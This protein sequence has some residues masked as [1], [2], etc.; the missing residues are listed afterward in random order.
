MLHLVADLQTF[1]ISPLF[2]NSRC[3]ARI[4]LRANERSRVIFINNQSTTFLGQNKNKVFRG[5]KKSN[6]HVHFLAFSLFFSK[7]FKLEFILYVL[8]FFH[9]EFSSQ[10]IKRCCLSQY[11]TP[12][13]QFFP[14]IALLKGDSSS[15]VRVDPNFKDVVSNLSE[16]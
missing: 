1:K 8:S 6:T 14:K 5:Q 10:C 15:P 16:V 4:V 7:Y 9:S 2:R 3:I 13:N 11:F 12:T